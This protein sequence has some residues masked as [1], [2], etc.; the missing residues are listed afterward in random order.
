[1]EGLETKVQNWNNTFHILFNG[2][3]YIVHGL[4][5]QGTINN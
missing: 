2:K 1:M 5:A 3:E 4:T